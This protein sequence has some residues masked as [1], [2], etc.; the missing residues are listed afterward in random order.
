M[1]ID[2]K[3]TVGFLAAGAAIYSLYRL[4]VKHDSVKEAIKK[5][6]EPTVKTIEHPIKAVEEVIK[7]AEIIVT[8]P[9]KI[10]KKKYSRFVKGSPEA[11]EYMKNLKSLKKGHPKIN[12]HKGHATKR[13]LAQ[14]QKLISKQ[15]HE[16]AYQ[17]KKRK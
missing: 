3:K 13:G 2:I 1:A 9:V 14:D 17:K 4:F 15:K 7:E 11:K 12:S 8:E 5:T 6:V 10:V 16:K